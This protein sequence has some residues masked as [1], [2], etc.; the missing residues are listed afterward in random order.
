MAFKFFTDD[1]IVPNII[2][3]YPFPG[4]HY[5]VALVSSA[6]GLDPILVYHK[7]R[8]LWGVGA[9]LFVY[10][11]ASLLFP[12]APRLAF[13]STWV[14]VLFVLAGSFADV[15]GFYWAQL[16][17]FTHISDLAMN[18]LLPGCLVLLFSY[19]TEERRSGRNFFFVA[20]VAQGVTLT[21]VHPRE[22]VQFAVYLAAFALVVAIPK[23]SRTYAMRA[24]AVL[25]VVFSIGL[26]YDF[27]HSQTVLHV[28]ALESEFRKAGRAFISSMPLGAY[29]G[30]PNKIEFRYFSGNELFFLGWNWL[31]LLAGPI[32]LVA[33]Q[34][35]IVSVFVAAAVLGYAAILRFPIVGLAYRATTYDEILV[36]PV[37]N[38]V[39]FIYL[40]TGAALYLMTALVSQLRPL[41][42][43]WGALAVGAIALYLAWRYGGKWLAPRSS[44]FLLT[45][46]ILYSAALAAMLSKWQIAVSHN[47]IF[48]FLLL[49][50]ALA[51]ATA[52]PRGSVLRVADS[53]AN[54][55]QL[56]DGL[57]CK[58]K[59]CAPPW[60]LVRWARMNLPPNAVFA[61]NID[62]EVFPSL[63]MPQRLIAWPGPGIANY[64]NRNNFPVFYKHYDGTM[65]SIRKQPFFNEE[66][67]L[68]SRLEFIR[69]LGATHVL[70]DP[71]VHDL[72]TGVLGR[73]PVVFKL[74][75][76][77]DYWAVYE[78]SPAQGANE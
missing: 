17:P 60:K 39:F 64:L 50:V 32:V 15:P 19:L 20:T 44:L 10:A 26:A 58:P 40:L 21:M 49:S 5:L 36:S 70:L 68:E 9:L 62:N 16:V 53:K 56:I 11:G 77:A 3:T 51:I 24:A 1:Y 34:R 46:V 65:S 8:F 76:D 57:G 43:Q 54:E 33:W 55:Q 2:Y 23:W 7:L 73:W 30:D 18:L 71:S 74:V 38:V 28:N 4:L 22:A 72:M 63:T 13:A 61:L 45:T 6:S 12:G 41:L 35:S 75:Y 25:V 59:A 27:W 47:G 42:L 48:A 31:A 78:I 66:E 14:A 37:R 67:N 29:F 69:D 52:E